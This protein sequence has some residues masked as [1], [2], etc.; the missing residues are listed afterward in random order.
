MLQTVN[1]QADLLD[2]SRRLVEYY[3][4]NEKDIREVCEPHWAINPN[5]TQAVENAA[6][7][8]MQRLPLDSLSAR[9][10]AGMWFENNPE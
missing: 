1:V 9:L 2:H 7:D 3:Y 5:V 8:L 6:T 10:L 4:R